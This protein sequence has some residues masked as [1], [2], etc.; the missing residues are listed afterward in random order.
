MRERR[1][2]SLA[3]KARSGAVTRLA[4]VATT[5]HERA[6]WDRPRPLS[7]L[8]A[9][10]NS[11]KKAAGSRAMQTATTILA[12]RRRRVPEAARSRRADWDSEKPSRSANGLESLS[13][14]GFRDAPPRRSEW[15]TCYRK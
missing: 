3:N 8:S 15:S 10:V 6:I 2:R 12:V 11:A 13:L 5:G 9:S 1:N 4:V 14:N 7:T